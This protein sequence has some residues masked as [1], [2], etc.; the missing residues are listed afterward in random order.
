MPSLNWFIMDSGL[1][2]IRLLSEPQQKDLP[3]T[4]VNV[5]DNPDVIK[6]FKRD[7]LI[8]TTGFVFKEHPELIESSIQE[9]KRAGCCALGIKVP[10]FF[11]QVPASLLAIADKYK[12]P[13]LELPYFYSFSEI[14]QRVFHQID[15]EAF[16]G[17][18][19]RHSILDQLLHAV[20]SHASLSE[21]LALTASQLDTISIFLD[22]HQRVLA[23]GIPSGDSV[24]AAKLMEVLSKPRFFSKHDLSAIPLCFQEEQYMMTPF[25]LP[26]KCGTLCLA[27]SQNSEVLPDADFMQ[28]LVQFFA[29][30]YEQNHLSERSYE[31]QTSGFLHYM[32]DQKNA[33]LS[34]LRDLCS[35]YGFPYQK[36]WVCLTISTRQLPDEHKSDTLLILRS[37][38][39]ELTG[40]EQTLL[41]YADENIFCSF[42]IFPS[43]FHALQAVQE[44]EKITKELLMRISHVTT[45]LLPAGFSTFRTELPGIRRAFEESL[46]AMTTQKEYES[47]VSASYLAQLPIHILSAASPEDKQLLVRNM[48]HP[49]IHYDQ[50][51]HTELQVTLITY[52]QENANITAAAKALFLHRNTMIHRINKIKELLKLKL[53][54]PQELL[55]LRLALMTQQIERKTAY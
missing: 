4:S 43:D 27:H 30:S 36:G 1:N 2:N 7:E 18:H 38:L 9:M 24:Q 21:L 29:L 40:Q 6:W 48:L 3:I 15:M 31:N 42:F 47:Q 28:S 12:L 51:N 33:T 50:E 37:L 11:R 44:V 49:L 54:D 8:L 45:A 35:F 10:R 16:A 53:E 46:Q 22:H 26:N 41:S 20:L 19:R 23:C 55:L 52:L 34:E 13:I 5:L 39:K 32:L 25:E 14:M 17:Q